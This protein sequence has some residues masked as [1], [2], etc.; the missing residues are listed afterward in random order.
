MIYTLTLNPAV[1]LELQIDQFQ[2]NSVVRAGSS[3]MDCGGKGFNVSRMLRNLG[4]DSTA[5]GFIGGYN[6]ERLEAE[7]TALGIQTRFT[8]ISGETRT[9]VSIVANNEAQHIKVNEAGP[10]ILPAELSNLIE[11]V[12]QNLAAGDWWVLAGSLPRGVDD[13]VYADL[14]RLIEGAGAHAILDTSGEALRLGCLAK[15]S[16]VKPNLEEAQQLLGLPDAALEQADDWTNALLD[17]GPKSLV[18]SLGKQGALLATGEY[19]GK[20]ESPSIVEA[21]PIGAGDSMVAGIV[22]RLSLGEPLR[23]AL[24]YGL[25]CGAATASRS[26]TEL[27]S[28]E[29]VTELVKQC[30][31]KE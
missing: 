25:A 21:N 11:A 9:N 4:V 16:L 18:V 17:L 15:P 19:L 5:M 6:G 24:P 14:I 26:G 1:D 31:F 20:V 29:Q 7:L 2:F 30:K 27:G 3:R 23:Q 8:K 22:W 28:L 12:K 13:S 10:E